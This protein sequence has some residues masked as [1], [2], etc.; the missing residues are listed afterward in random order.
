M[1]GSAQK[2]RCLVQSGRYN[3]NITNNKGYTPL[4]VAV[5]AQNSLAVV[6]LL[7]HPECRTKIKDHLGMTPLKKAAVEDAI[8]CVEVLILSG[9][10]SKEGIKEAIEKN[11]IL[12]QAVASVS[13]V[14]S[15]YC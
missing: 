1:R 3:V 15:A 10:C 5:A 7:E 2:V 6:I 12:H 14:L 8:Y 9:K 13:D 4:H 11:S